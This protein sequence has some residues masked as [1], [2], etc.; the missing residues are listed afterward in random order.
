MPR[1]VPVLTVISIALLHLAFVFAVH[2]T[3]FAA[4]DPETVAARLSELAMPIAAQD[5]AWID[6]FVGNVRIVLVG[7]ELHGIAEH[8]DLKL[9]VAE[10]LIEQ[11]GFTHVFLED[12]VFKADSL[13]WSLARSE[14]EPSTFFREFFWCWNVEE[15][16]TGFDRW[17]NRW[18]E[19]P[20][21]HGMDVQTPR[22]ALRSLRHAAHTVTQTQAVESLEQQFRGGRSTYAARSDEAKRR[23]TARID[24]LAAVFGD[25]D[26]GREQRHLARVQRVWAHADDHGLRMNARD[27]G[28]A[29]S[30][31]DVLALDPSFKAVIFAHNAHAGYEPFYESFTS[32]V[33]PV[34]RH[35]RDRGFATL[36]IG[37][38]FATGTTLLDPRARERE[39]GETRTIETPEPET[40]AVVWERMP[41]ERWVLD[42]RATDLGEG[43]DPGVASGFLRAPP[44]G[45]FDNY[46]PARPLLTSYDLLVGYRRVTSA[47]P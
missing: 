1:A 34:G 36:A 38:V 28:M 26:I 7:E 30:V 13:R 22:Y 32:G 46:G 39:G 42:L 25:V 5:G 2:A 35:L 12:D 33:V 43:G 17:A 3:V 11:H 20:R 29:E 8:L 44:A 6:P 4:A 40:Q 27:R 24:A 18:T 10:R 47:S 23:D 15:F 9:E 21:V 37:A 45:H 19:P 41:H 16:R 14:H 31:G